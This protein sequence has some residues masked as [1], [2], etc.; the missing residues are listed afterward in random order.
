DISNVQH[1]EP[2]TTTFDVFA[3]LDT[4]VFYEQQNWLAGARLYSGSIRARMRANVVVS[5]ELKSRMEIGRTLLPEEII[6]IR[7]TSA[8]LGYQHRAVEHIGGVGGD[9]AKILGEAI[10]KLLHQ[11]HPSLEPQ[12]LAKADQTIVKAADT[13][14]IRLGLESFLKPKKSQ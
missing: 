9:G 14:E 7:A 1:P 12:L 4:R 6:R 3:A 2:G 5:C 10:Y 13:K 8:R 11:L